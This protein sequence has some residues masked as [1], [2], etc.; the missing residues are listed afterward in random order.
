MSVQ[1]RL[2]QLEEAEPAAGIG[3]EIW[4]V[5]YAWMDF[6]KSYV[7]RHPEA[8]QPATI[9]I[10]GDSYPCTIARVGKGRVWVKRDRIRGPLSI[11]DARAPEELYVWSEKQERLVSKTRTLLVGVRY[12]HFPRE[13]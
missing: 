2:D 7:Q 5:W 10:G 6:A 13:F 1:A 11:P 8:G 4:S 12:A 9:S 3:H